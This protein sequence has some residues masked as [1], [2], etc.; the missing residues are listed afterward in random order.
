MI[1]VIILL[2]SAVNEISRET[3]T[4]NTKM[5]RKRLGAIGRNKSVGPDVV[6]GE[7]LKLGVQAMIPYLVRFLDIT[8]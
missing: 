6:P 1:E 8:V 2:Y 4:I 7:I 3:F 5:I